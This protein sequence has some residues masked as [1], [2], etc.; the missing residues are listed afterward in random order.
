MGG[1]KCVQDEFNV[2]VISVI[3]RDPVKCN[4]FFSSST[5]A[6]IQYHFSLE[7]ASHNTGAKI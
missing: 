5:K 6:N 4:M 7:T 1:N 3:N 2:V